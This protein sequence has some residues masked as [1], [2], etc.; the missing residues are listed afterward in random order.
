MRDWEFVKARTATQGAVW[1]SADGLLYKRTGGVDL[2]EEINF[3][4]LVD[5]LGYPV[6]EIVDSG[7]ENGGYYVV[8]RS[9]GNTSLHEE[10]LTDA[11]QDGQ[12][13]HRVIAAAA[14][15]SSK[16]LQA[17]VCHPVPAASPW[18]E[19]AA[20]AK[21]VFEEN[22]EFDTLRVHNTI[23]RALDR[24]AQ[25]P[26]VRGHLDYGLPNV[27]GT[28]II[29]WQH[30]GPIPLG[31]D[32]YPAL[33]I[34]PFKGGGKGYTI[35][36]EQRSAYTAA[37]DETTASLIGQRVSE[38][39]GDF[40]L[41]KCFFFLAL[42][43]PTDPARHDKHIKWQYRRALFTMGLDQYESS[44]TIDT[45]AFPTLERFTAEYR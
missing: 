45:G 23:R 14:T 42:M 30:H 2:R 20:F 5:S 22:P 34:V 36:H 25:L 7:S 10:A 37:L 43:R 41:V 31:Y 39:L 29:D 18:F 1:K 24:L 35:S 28:G 3:Q 26:L 38:H 15:V 12:V 44:N 11:R 4:R 13:S 32:V 19:K 8:E 16:L 33:D 40:L 6:P 9:L 17:Q 27:L 21:N